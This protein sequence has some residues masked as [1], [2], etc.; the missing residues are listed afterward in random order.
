[1]KTTPIDDLLS[2]SVHPQESISE[3]YHENTKLFPEADFAFLNDNQDPVML[4]NKYVFQSDIADKEEFIA[5]HGKHY[6]TCDKITMPS[7]NLPKSISLKRALEDRCS[8]IAFDPDHSLELDKLS[9]L[10]F[11]GYGLRDSAVTED[12]IHRHV[13]SAGALY[14]L[15]IYILALRLDGL[16]ESSLLHYQPRGHYLEV[17]GTCPNAKAVAQSCL[18]QAE[19][20]E[21]G[22]VIFISGCTPRVK[23]KYGERGYRYALLEAGHVVQNLCLT[24]TVT[25]LKA[26]PIAGYYDDAVHDL[27]LLDGVSEIVLYCLCIG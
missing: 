11:Y 1:M 8:D 13:P 25:G 23:W 3:W 14:P 5:L 26:C 16:N 2:G 18:V 15:E 22:A 7:P 17:L 6:S 12:A 10:L 20:F 4:A 24:A 19:T 27:F 9:T 21:A